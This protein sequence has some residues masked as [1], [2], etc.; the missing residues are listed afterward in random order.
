MNAVRPPEKER[1]DPLAGGGAQAFRNPK[2]REMAEAVL[3][4]SPH[5]RN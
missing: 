1:P 2:H 3:A 5:L 4:Q